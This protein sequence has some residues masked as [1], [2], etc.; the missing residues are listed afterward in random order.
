MARLTFT[1]VE[2]ACDV[3][4]LVTLEAG[5]VPYIT[6]LTKEGTGGHGVPLN[7]DLLLN[8]GAI[9]IDWTPPVVVAPTATELEC[10]T[11]LPAAETTIA[12]FLAL[13]GADA[14]DICTAQGDL[15][16]T[17]MTGALSGT[18]CLG[19]ITRTYTITDECGNHADVNH[20]FNVSDD[21][22]PTFTSCPSNIQV[23]ADAGGCTA[24]LTVGGATATDDCTGPPAITYWD[25]ATEIT[26]AYTFPTG[27]TTVTVMAE[28][29]CGNV[30][31]TCTFTV[32]VLAFNDFVV[33]IQIQ[34]S[35]S[36][37]VTRCIT[38]TFSD[39]VGAD[40]VFNR[41]I[42]FDSSGMASN[43]FFDDLACS[44]TGY[45]CVTAQ[46]DL[47]TLLRQGFAGNRETTNTVAGFTGTITCCC[48]ATTTMTSRTSAL[49]SLTS[50]TLACSSL[51]GGWSGSGDTP[52][53][54]PWP[55]VDAD[56]S[57]CD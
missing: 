14:S 44:A 16:V 18:E 57:G 36:N 41:D 45:T 11:E 23:N 49:T 48:R 25:G 53:G 10:S 50:S 29:G 38:F 33:D 13:P 47:H 32:E 20:V 31:D 54:T 35:M 55:H 9:R 28:D 34:G 22:A 40:V 43:V 5:T 27:T 24:T 1:T 7:A 6:R 51:S 2:E 3:A 8:L 26:G 56:G 17:S 15:T 37:A 52:C 19:T 39:C 46:D 12:G 21:T 42:A 4:D 30:N